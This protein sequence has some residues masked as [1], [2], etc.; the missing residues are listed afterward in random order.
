M[1][2]LC[3][4]VLGYLLIG[5]VT[6]QQYVLQHVQPFFFVEECFRYIFD[7]ARALMEEQ[8]TIDILSVRDALITDI[9]NAALAARIK[10]F[11]EY[12]VCCGDLPKHCSDEDVKTQITLLLTQI[13]NG[14]TYSVPPEIAVKSFTVDFVARAKKELLESYR[15]KIKDAP[16]LDFSEELLHKLKEL[17]CYLRSSTWELYVYDLLKLENE[18]DDVALISYKDEGMFFRGNIYLI[19]GYAGCMKSFLSLVLAAATFNKGVGADKTLSF[20]STS[21]LNKVLFVDTELAKNT[22]KK[23]WKAF[24]MMVGG[25]VEPNRFKYLALRKVPGSI[26]TKIQLIDEACDQFQPDLLVIDSIRDLCPDYNDSREAEKTVEHIKFIATKLNCVIITTSHRSLGVGNP[27]GHLGMRLNEAAG[28]EMSLSSKTDTGNVTFVQVDFNKMRDGAY[29]PFSFRYD[30]D[31]ELPVEY[32]PLVD[33]TEERNKKRTAE[34]LVLACMKP[35]EQ[36]RYTELVRRIAA[37]GVVCESTAK[38]YLKALIGTVVVRDE[39]GNYML[40]NPELPLPLDDDLPI[41]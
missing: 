25:A 37:K 8:R 7:A 21:R 22:V 35:G 33:S 24:K 39:D 30:T 26:D 6:H 29:T 38:N 9:D 34:S 32:A 19:S 15:N 3:F 27:K 36:V 18:P 1:E 2:S 23:R 17:E 10:A 14:L 20:S 11:K 13:T 16:S 4:V 41:G 5:E 12:F 40:A 28:L 31:L